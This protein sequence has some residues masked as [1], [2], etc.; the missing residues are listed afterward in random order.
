MWIFPLRSITEE[1]RNQIKRIEKLAQIR[2]SRAEVPFGK[3]N[4]E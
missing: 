1:G 4:E 3:A 2:K